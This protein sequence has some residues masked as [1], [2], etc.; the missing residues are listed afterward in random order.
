MDNT[1]KF[2]FYQL[3]DDILSN[4]LPTSLEQVE[5]LAGYAMAAK[6]GPW[7]SKKHPKHYLDGQR[8]LPENLLDQGTRNEQEWEERVTHWHKIFSDKPHFECIEGYLE[9]AEN[10]DQYGT[11]YYNVSS[12]GKIFHLGVNCRG[13]QFYHMS[14]KVNPMYKGEFP[15]N[16]I[17]N[18]N[19]KGKKFVI[20]FKEGRQDLNIESE[21]L[22]SFL[23]ENQKI[24]TTTKEDQKPGIGTLSNLFSKSKT[25]S[26]AASNYTVKKYVVKI[27]SEAEAV[28]ILDQCSGYHAIY[29]YSLAG[30]QT[31]EKIK[32]KYETN[33]KRQEIEKLHQRSYS[34]SQHDN[35]NFIVASQNRGL[36]LTRLDESTS[37]LRSEGN[38]LVGSNL[39]DL[40]NLVNHKNTKNQQS[41]NNK[42]HEYYTQ[43]NQTP[44]SLRSRGRTGSVI[45]QTVN[46]PSTEKLVDN[47]EKYGQNAEN[48][49][50]VGEN[51]ARQPHNSGDSFMTQDRF[52]QL[53][54]ELKKAIYK[55]K[56]PSANQLTDSQVILQKLEELERTVLNLQPGGK[57]YLDNGYNSSGDELYEASLFPRKSNNFGK[58]SDLEADLKN[59]I[60]AIIASRNVDLE[61]TSPKSG[62]KN[63]SVGS[64]TMSEITALQQPVPHYAS[65]PASNRNSWLQK[66][67]Y[68]NL[69]EDN[70]FLISVLRKTD[71]FDKMPFIN[72]LYMAA[73]ADKFEADKGGKLTFA[74]QESEEF[75]ILDHGQCEIISADGTKSYGILK[76]GDTIG[77]ESCLKKLKRNV[78]V[79]ANVQ[80]IFWSISYENIPLTDQNIDLEKLKQIVEDLQIDTDQIP[81][82][83]EVRVIEYWD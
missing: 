65:M 60:D 5:I 57:Y 16:D 40:K 9:N 24:I 43:N 72:Q 45:S 11:S 10:L 41:N 74:G 73:T 32:M 13:I 33:Q 8:Y 46:H 48:F 81:P 80:T 52:N 39:S 77:V 27:N 62:M 82:E 23:S 66:L 47:L 83:L 58:K 69:D 25:S 76:K 26:T 6:F 49:S 78:S 21:S 61:N 34:L 71:P 15:W 20:E 68:E 56:K 53:V 70:Q 36:N 30:N 67:N 19:L 79:V 55:S 14:D 59:K 1:R 29:L 38:T 63:S 7:N 28:D 37:S 31:A 51:Q 12:S 22:T 2:F 4:R 17:K 18:I 35:E 64:L 44:S 42:Y 54:S 75:F 50:Q 3:R